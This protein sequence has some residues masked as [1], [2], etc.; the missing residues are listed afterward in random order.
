MNYKEF[1]KYV[2]EHILEFMPPDFKD[3]RVI[4]E[5]TIKNNHTNRVGLVVLKEDTVVSSKLYLEE[6]YEKYK[7]D[8]DIEVTMFSIGEEYCARIYPSKKINLEEII[9]FDKIKDRIISTVINTKSNLDT[10]SNRPHLNVND[11]SVIYQIHL[12]TLADNEVNIPISYDL[13]DEW[14]VRTDDIHE[15]AIKNTEKIYPACLY[16]I[17][18]K[19]D[20][21]NI[22]FLDEN[23]E[24]PM[25][26]MLVLT[27][28]DFTLGAIALANKDTLLRVSKALDDDYYMMPT[29][30]DETIIIPKEVA[31]LSNL[32]P[33][34]LKR[35]LNEISATQVKKEDR[36]SSL[37][38][39]YNQDNRS[40]S[41]CKEL[42]RD[43]ER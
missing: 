2:K 7:V 22:N 23:S 8:K 15:S 20:D 36:L 31:K 28:K 19:F 41:V 38:Y 43:L 17:R 14:E 9:D 18:S 5:D 13:M 26:P 21:G 39:E 35:M 25:C 34:D 30:I 3:S 27:N 1:C 37:V 29:S 42:L 10:I 11:L 24:K 33:Q 4:V 40:L 16:D 12:G 6:F 32:K